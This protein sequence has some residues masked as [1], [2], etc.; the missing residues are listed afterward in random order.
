MRMNF[1]LLPHD[2][3]VILISY[4]NAFKILRIG[5]SIS[6]Q[7]DIE[8]VSDLLAWSTSNDEID[9]E[10]TQSFIPIIEEAAVKP[11]STDPDDNRDQLPPTN[12]ELCLV[13]Q[14]KGSRRSKMVSL[15]KDGKAELAIRLESFRNLKNQGYIFPD[16]VFEYRLPADISEFLKSK[17][18]KAHKTCLLRYNGEKLKRAKDSASRYVLSNNASMDVT[19]P[20][21]ST[22]ASPSNVH[23]RAS[24]GSIPIQVGEKLCIFCGTTEVRDPKHPTN[25]KLLHKAGDKNIRDKSY[26]EKLTQDWL[27]KAIAIG[28]TN[29]IVHLSSGDVRATECY[30]HAECLKAFHNDFNKAFITQAQH[31]NP[32]SDQQTNEFITLCATESLRNYISDSDSSSFTVAELENVYN[33]AVRNISPSSSVHSTRFAAYLEENKL[34]LDIEILQ[35]TAGLPYK[36]IR[37][38]TFQIPAS[39]DDLFESMRKV[40]LEIRKEIKATHL[41]S[42]C[43]ADLPRN[44]TF[45]CEKLKMLITL[46][47][48]RNPSFT[49]IAEPYETICQLI[50]MH[51]KADPRAS[52]LIAASSATHGRVAR[53]KEAPI[54]RYTTMKAYSTIRSKVLHNTLARK[55]ISISYSRMMEFTKELTAISNELFTRSFDC[56]LPSRVRLGIFTVFC[57]DNVDKNSRSVYSKRN[58]H[59]TSCSVLQFPSQ[60]CPGIKRF[61]KKYHELTKAEK[62]T[63]YSAALDNY[64]TI[65]TNVTLEKCGLHGG[66]QTVNYDS[67]WIENISESY[68]ESFNDQLSWVSLVADHVSDGDVDMECTCPLSFVAFECKKDAE[69]QGMAAGRETVENDQ[70]INCILPVLE[71]EAHSVSLEYHLLLLFKKYSSYINPDQTVVMCADQPLYAIHKQLQWQHSN[72]FLK[73]NSTAANVFF[74]LGP[75]HIEQVMYQ[76]TGQLVT[77]TGFDDALKA[78]GLDIVGIV[79][80][81]TDAKNL[82]RARYAGH[83]IASVIQCLLVDAYSKEID[84]STRQLIQFDVWLKQKTD[85]NSMY[86]KGILNHLINL[87]LLIK[88]IRVADFDLFT[89]VLEEACP[90]IFALDHTHYSRWVPVFVHELKLLKVSDPDLYEEFRKGNFVVSKTNIPFSKIA[91]DQCHE[92]N[93]KIIKSRSGLEDQLNKEDKGFLRQLENIMPEIIDYLQ[94]MDNLGG[95]SKTS[96]DESHP[97]FIKKFMKDVKSV[98]SKISTNPF[99]MT[100]PKRINSDVIFPACVLEGM[101]QV[102]TIGKPLVTQYVQNRIILG[103]ESVINTKISVNSLKLPREAEKH[104]KDNPV[105]ALKP[106]IE[107]KLRDATTHRPH[108]AKKVFEREFTGGPEALIKDGH[109]F[110]G[111]KSNILKC[112]LPEKSTDDSFENLQFD[113]L[114]VD[115]SVEVRS[116]ARMITGGSYTFKRFAVSVLDSIAARFGKYGVTQIDVVADFYFDPSIKS[117]TRDQRGT[118]S[119]HVFNPDDIIPDNFEEMLNNSDFKDDLNQLFCCIDVLMNWAWGGDFAVTDGEYIL[120]RISG[121]ISKRKILFQPNI[122]S[123]EEAD[124]RMLLHIRDLLDLRSKTT[125]LVRTLDSDVVVLLT[126]FF[127]QFSQYNVDVVLSVEF[128]TGAARKIYSINSVYNHLGEGESLGIMFFHAFTG[129][130]ST[131][132]IFRKGKQ[133]I[134]DAWMKSSYRDE[135]TMIFQFL[136]WRPDVSRIKLYFPVICKFIKNL[137]GCKSTN[138]SLDAFKLRLFKNSSKTNM[139]ELPPTSRSL[140][141]HVLRSCY[142]A[143]WI[144]SNTINQ[145]PNPPLNEF[146]WIESENGLKIQWIDEDNFEET[147]PML[148]NLAIKTCSCQFQET[149]DLSKKCINCSCFKAGVKC[150]NQCKCSRSCQNV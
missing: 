79:K 103:T 121:N 84:E 10:H 22:V 74:F 68:Q 80:A 116:N 31:T 12:S 87:N 1:E 122:T 71:Q 144:W 47:C 85:T 43:M 61:K 40:A 4:L 7:T 135:L 29:V 35:K 42:I 139:R 142:Q 105:M 52:R 63:M 88:S 90:L 59:G 110:K 8:G 75:M 53:T 3:R 127:L 49:D 143:G 97:N 138:E 36:I 46:I 118:S 109:A 48:T 123:L 66:I 72:K 16:E 82:K 13:C 106:E 56:V 147:T 92:Q 45:T 150:L 26:P 124:N 91:L 70:I 113:A 112:I 28:K 117:G 89:A 136:S 15:S 133:S 55:G 145:E 115:L 50:A 30:Y 96:H 131:S 24:S 119:R 104:I 11:L 33:E 107:T 20:T 148:L 27:E 6:T 108:L 128:G 137:Y 93:N 57:V 21:D 44:E 111:T 149:S 141:L 132:F 17:D 73:T 5:I 77:G 34:K 146:G 101:E 23:T 129:C 65:D 134:F 62:T 94:D 114:V 60:H 32:G 14:D 69:V 95:W 51:F 2:T 83:L 78:A 19:E 86:Y 81:L 37:K 120:E 126:A 100:I 67:D 58:F 18:F 102:F 99:L 64:L 140:F 130:D 41:S 9:E 125:I 54:I 98:Y 39:S 76:I 25:N 38:S